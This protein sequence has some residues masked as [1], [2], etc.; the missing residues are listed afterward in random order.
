MVL[1]LL[2]LARGNP[3]AI[4]VSCTR[5]SKYLKS[6]AKRLLLLTERGGHFGALRPDLAQKRMPTTARSAC[7]FS[8]WM[9]LP[10]MGIVVAEPSFFMKP[11]RGKRMPYCSWP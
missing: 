11:S 1:W 10:P 6:Q 8:G 2:T 4:G 7:G 9:R 3:G 5:A